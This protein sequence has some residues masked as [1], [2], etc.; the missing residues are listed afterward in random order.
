M[1]NYDYFD[2]KVF[3]SMQRKIYF[4]GFLTILQTEYWNLSIYMYY[5]DFSYVY[6]K[7]EDPPLHIE[8]SFKYVSPEDFE[9]KI[10]EFCKKNDLHIKGTFFSEA[11][12]DE[13]SPIEYP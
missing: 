13:H 1:A 11:T 5:D 8:V 12:S 7:K 9:E 10:I 4:I 2:M 3:G 6:N